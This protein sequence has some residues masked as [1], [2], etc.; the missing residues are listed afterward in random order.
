M[1]TAEPQPQIPE[2]S[3]EGAPPGPP[4]ELPEDLRAPW[5]WLDLLIFF[6]Y[7]LGSVMV[8]GRFMVIAAVLW[9]IVKPARAMDLA[10]AQTAWAVVFQAT[11]SAGLLVYL[12]A[13]IRVRFG[14]PFWRTIGFREFRVRELP[15]ASGYAVCALGGMVL[16]ILAQVASVFLPTEA[17]LPIQAYFQT[18]ASVVL[19]MAMGVA[20]A[21]LAEETVFRG[22]LYPV[23]A[24]SLGKPAGVVLVGLLFGLMHAAQLGGSWGH[25]GVLGMVGV[26]LT[27]ARARTGTVLASYLLHLGYNSYLFLGFYVFTGGLR[28]LPGA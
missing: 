27:Y 16:A 7:A 8:I 18:R 13:V 9:G 2:L 12:Y 5:N 21:P 6:F 11:W 3:P 10:T 22:Y 1:N 20:V 23:F 14:T 4:R 24:R 28:H 25:I 15:P 17:K 26:A 19:M